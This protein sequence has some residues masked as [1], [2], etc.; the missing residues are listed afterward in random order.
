MQTIIPTS[1]STDTHVH[2]LKTKHLWMHTKVDRRTDRRIYFHIGMHKGGQTDGRT[3]R[4]K[5][6]RPTGGQ[7]MMID[8]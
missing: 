6:I 7:M 8:V 3:D 5:D 1:T 4:Q 2:A